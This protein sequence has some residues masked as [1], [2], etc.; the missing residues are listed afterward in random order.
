MAFLMPTKKETFQS[1]KVGHVHHRVSTELNLKVQSKFKKKVTDFSSHLGQ[2]KHNA[3]Q[4][5]QEL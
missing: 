2:E 1:I 3:F 5:Y 4:L